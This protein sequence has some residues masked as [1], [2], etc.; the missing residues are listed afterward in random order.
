MNFFRSSRSDAVGVLD[1][2]AEEAVVLIGDKTAQGQLR[3]IGSG[4]FRALGVDKGQIVNIGD[5]VESVAEAASRAE[6]SAG[7]MLKTLFY[8]LDDPNIE[9][10]RPVGSRILDGEGEIQPLDIK[11]AVESARRMAG[12]YDKTILYAKETDF[13]VDDKDAVAD[14]LGIFGHKI[15]LT[16][17]TLLVRASHFDAWQKILRRAG[18]SK[19]KPV[20]SGLSVVRGVLTDE[21]Q[22]ETRVVWDLGKDLLTGVVY[23]NNR[24]RAYR[25]IAHDESL[26][27]Q[28][29]S[30]ILA[31]TQGWQQEFGGILETV[32]AGDL[33]E[34]QKIISALREGTALPVRRAQATLEGMPGFTCASLAGLLKIA[35]EIKKKSM[36]LRPKKDVLAGMKQKAD[37]FLN[38]YF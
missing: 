32:V 31:V 8:N 26:W 15:N 25:V 20:L 23:G 24:V 12:D 17:E 3:V 33:A 30:V 6:R 35:Y 19:A 27:D 9:A 18:F 34:D 37:A 16:L 28:S 5:A 14:P 4:R 21:Q 1:F 7:M 2:G 38:D 13:V 10:R 36:I 29:S 11:Q 22:K